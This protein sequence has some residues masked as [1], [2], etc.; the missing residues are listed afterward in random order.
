MNVPASK[1]SVDKGK[2]KATSN[3]KKPTTKA[4]GDSADKEDNGPKAPLLKRFVSKS[5]NDPTKEE[6]VPNEDKYKRGR[7]LDFKVCA[8]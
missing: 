2:A 8:V 5:K 1:K 3:N 6:A 7:P 4:T